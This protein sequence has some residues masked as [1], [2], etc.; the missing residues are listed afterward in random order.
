MRLWVG[1]SI[2]KREF[3]G[4][5]PAEAEEVLQ[6][7]IKP[8]L[9]LAIKGAE[10]PARTQL[11]KAYAT[12]RHGPRRIVLLFVVEQDDLFLLFYRPKGDKVGDNVSVKNPA[13]K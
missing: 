3:G 2:L 10:L 1:K 8:L 6:R 13:F 5:L 12:S 11:L 9:L 4:R 7:A